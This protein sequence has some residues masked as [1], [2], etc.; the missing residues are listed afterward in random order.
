M[1]T[2]RLRLLFTHGRRP[3]GV[4]RAC[5]GDCGAGHEPG[6]SSPRTPVVG[7]ALLWLVLPREERDA[8]VGDLHEEFAGIVLPQR[9]AWRARGWYWGQVLRSVAP[10]LVL[11]WQRG[12]RP[13]L[14][15]GG[16]A[17]LVAA[18]LPLLAAEALRRFVLSQVPLR[19]SAAHSA[20]YLAAVVSMGLLLAGLGGWAG[21]RWVGRAAEEDR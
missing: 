6:S 15:A 8:V 19:A 17:A 3:A 1:R 16:A 4:A 13:P 20:S 18:G 14:L 12:G 5:R 2:E 10:L 7:R 9:G 11:R 21:M